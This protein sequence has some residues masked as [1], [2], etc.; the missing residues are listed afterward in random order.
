VHVYLLTASRTSPSSKS[1]SSR[2]S[3]EQECRPALRRRRQSR[4]RSAARTP[5][6][7]RG[8]LRRAASVSKSAVDIERATP[9]ILRETLGD[10]ESLH[11]PPRPI[12]LK[13]DQDEQR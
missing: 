4:I 11:L 5:S 2:R 10:T 12:N 9:T 3:L 13:G 1:L 8:A 6:R 7:G